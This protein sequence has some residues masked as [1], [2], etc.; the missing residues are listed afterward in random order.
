M[1]E[2]EWGA[3]AEN[4]GIQFDIGPVPEFRRT[5]AI[6]CELLELGP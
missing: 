2:D 1:I 5:P 6:S 4:L 3:V